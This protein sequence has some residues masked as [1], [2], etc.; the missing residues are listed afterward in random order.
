MPI[1]VVSK[2][3]ILDLVVENDLEELRGLYEDPSVKEY[4][5]GYPT[6]HTR[7]K[8]QPDNLAEFIKTRN[9]LLAIRLRTSLEF[10]GIIGFAK[11]NIDDGSKTEVYCAVKFEHRGNAFAHEAIAELLKFVFKNTGWEEVIGKVQKTNEASINL[12]KK[13]KY[14]KT[15]DFTDPLTGKESIIYFF[16]KTDFDV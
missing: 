14:N 5:G 9:L 4:I 16:T 2:Q 11:S 7:A 8:F 12:I 3:L 15:Q 10:I 6:R 1:N 13:L